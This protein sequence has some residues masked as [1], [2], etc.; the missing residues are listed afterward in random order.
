MSKQAKKKRLRVISSQ[1]TNECFLSGQHS[2]AT[3]QTHGSDADIST[4]DSW[5]GHGPLHTFIPKD[6]QPEGRR[7]SQQPPL[8]SP[9]PDQP[10]EPRA[11]LIRGTRSAPFVWQKAASPGPRSAPP[12][13]PS[14]RAATRAEHPQRPAA[15]RP[16]PT[17]APSPEERSCGAGPRCPPAVAKNGRRPLPD[18]DSP[19]PSRSLLP[20]Y[21]RPGCPPEE[22][23]RRAGPGGARRGALAPPPRSAGGGTRGGAG[24]GGLRSEESRRGTAGG[25]RFRERGERLPVGSAQGRGFSCG[26]GGAWGAAV[27]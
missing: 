6:V 1:G 14:R 3:R 5:D 2:D 17:A 19:L 16:P 21:L 8:K 7:G 12:D 4:G 10:E 24:P 11:A 22:R 23:V 9:T 26:W 25:T 27:W 18:L 20:A 13:A 15:P